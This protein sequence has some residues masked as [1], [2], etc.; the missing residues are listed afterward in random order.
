MPTPIRAHIL[1]ALIGSAIAALR[2]SSDGSSGEVP[3]TQQGVSSLELPAAHAWDIERSLQQVLSGSSSGRRS[4]QGLQD[5]NV[6]DLKKVVTD[7]HQLPDPKY[8]QPD[9]PSVVA[10]LTA[11]VKQQQDGEGGTGSGTDSSGG[12]ASHRGGGDNGRGDDDDT[13][14]TDDRSRSRAAAG[15]R[16]RQQQ[17]QRL[18]GA[19]ALSLVPEACRAFASQL[20]QPP[21]GPIPRG[22]ATCDGG[23][24]LVGNCHH[25]LGLCMCPAGW[26]GPNCAQP[27]KRPCTRR[28]RDRDEKGPI[29]VILS[30]IDPVTKHDLNWTAIGWTASRCAGYCDDDIAMCYCGYGSV[31]AYVPAPEGSPPG[32]PALRVGRPM[33]DSCKPDHDAAGI[34]AG[35]NLITRFDGLPWDA[36]Y[37][38]TN[39]WCNSGVGIKPA[40]R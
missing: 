15:G 22:N 38:I 5:T 30:H 25:D 16:K 19:C 39:G 6:T 37:N 7:K 17:Q 34:M 4:L 12:A 8:L 18:S 23:C 28:V 33:A 20:P 36:L 32:T 11:E 9:D 3:P 10:G 27:L 21:A 2:A 29:G 1:L 31:H 14:P 24:G 13:M 35:S 40:H 26:T